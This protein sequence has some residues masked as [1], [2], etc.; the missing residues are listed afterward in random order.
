MRIY[1]LRFT[2]IFY[3]GTLFENLLESG[4][5]KAQRVGITLK[6]YI[7]KKGILFLLGMFMMVSTAEAINGKTSNS[8]PGYYSYYKAKPIQ[9]VEK[10]IKFFIYPNGD[11]DFNTQTR[12]RFTTQYVYTNGRRY[13]KRVPFSKVRISRDHYGRVKRVGSVFINYNR[14]GKVSKV[15]SIFIDY[16]HRKLARV[17]GLHIKY[18]RYGGIRYVGHVK[19]RYSHRTYNHLYNGMIFDYYDTYFYNDDFYNNFDD[20]D[21]DDDYYYY[22]SKKG[23]GSKQGKIIKR[24]KVQKDTLE[25]RKKRS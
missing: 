24:K 3:F 4:S 23:K 2:Y 14:F 5:R 15:G 20:Y 17:G 18:N 22:K 7:M 16:H 21:E 8:K 11:L 12:S 1:K 13:T 9:F 19:S 25:V 6:P 10:G